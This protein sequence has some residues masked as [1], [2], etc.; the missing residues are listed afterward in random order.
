KILSLPQ[1]NKYLLNEGTLQ[2]RVEAIVPSSKEG[3]EKFGESYAYYWTQY[4]Y[5]ETLRALRAA[6]NGAEKDREDA[7]TI[8]RMTIMSRRAQLEARQK[9]EKSGLPT[10]FIRKE[11]EA[12]ELPIEIN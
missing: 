9:L 11:G 8:T 5:N 10:E 2:K 12:P 7:A 1:G 4:F 3:F 6:A